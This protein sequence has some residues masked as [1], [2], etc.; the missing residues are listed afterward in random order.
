MGDIFTEYKI[1]HIS[2][3]SVNA[4]MDVFTPVKYAKNVKIFVVV[5]V[6]NGLRPHV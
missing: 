4:Q 5:A 6:I 2:W 3:V 1:I